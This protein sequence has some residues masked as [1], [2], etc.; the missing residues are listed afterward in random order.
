[1]LDWSECNFVPT[2]LHVKRGEDEPWE[3]VGELLWTK[4]QFKEA[5]RK[6]WKRFLR[7]YPKVKALS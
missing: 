1:M 4:K 7:G 3:V 5:E 6:G 2:T